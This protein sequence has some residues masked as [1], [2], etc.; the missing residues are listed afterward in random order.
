[1]EEMDLSDQVRLRPNMFIGELG[2]K[3]GM[4]LL[5]GIVN[6]ILSTH[7]S[8]SIDVVINTEEEISISFLIKAAAVSGFVALYEKRDLRNPGMFFCVVT[9]SLSH[10]F[11]L[12]ISAGNIIYLLQFCDG[13]IV[14]P[15]KEIEK[16]TGDL[17]TVKCSF[18][19]PSLIISFPMDNVWPFQTHLNRLACL[20]PSSKIS[21]EDSRPEKP[22][23]MIFQRPNGLVHLM[24]ES[25]MH[26]QYV[27][28]NNGFQLHFNGIDDDI[29][30]QVLIDDENRLFYGQNIQAFFNGEPAH[31][32]CSHVI[33][34]IDA[35]KETGTAVR[36]ADPDFINRRYASL[37]DINIY[38]SI[39]VE[40]NDGRNE[41]KFTGSTW[42]QFTSDRIYKIIKQVV[43]GKLKEACNS[44]ENLRMIFAN[45]NN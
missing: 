13:K 5:T 23:N 8:T 33:A 30:Y 20:F 11:E 32:E 38:V 14:A 43:V 21:F 6:E 26:R 37:S 7:S 27:N 17:V 40:K 45:I 15:A 44:N 24:I 42:Y 31:P 19:L 1:M 22:V 18:T 3:G 29:S 2:A 12:T 34:A 4:K 36:K 16:A 25:F 39:Y 28:A 41:F 9:T 10:R 35:I